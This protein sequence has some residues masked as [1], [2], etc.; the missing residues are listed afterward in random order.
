MLDTELDW[1]S[2]LFAGRNQLVQ[3]WRWEPWWARAGHVDDIHHTEPPVDLIPVTMNVV[4]VV[5]DLPIASTRFGGTDLVEGVVIGVEHETIDDRI[6]I[7][8]L[9]L[10][11]DVEELTDLEL[12]NAP[13]LRRDRNRTVDRECSRA[14]T[15]ALVDDQLKIA[16]KGRIECGVIAAVHVDGEV[17]RFV[18][19]SLLCRQGRVARGVRGLGVILKEVG[20]CLRGK[21]FRFGWLN[22]W[23]L[24]DWVFRYPG[25]DVGG[26][27]H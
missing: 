26:L 27:R 24:N 17:L 20:G 19:G 16:R 18:S 22:H 14:G 4:V 6:I 23:L 3:R 7:A 2:R 8:G 1:S 10:T 21:W 25:G 5:R 11:P 9:H 12:Q 13:G 15:D